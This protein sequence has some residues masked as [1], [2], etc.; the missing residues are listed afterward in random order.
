M[1]VFIW[2]GT[3]ASG[4]RIRGEL[5]AKNAKVVFNA[6]KSQ[7]INPIASKIKEKGKGL[8]MEI[9]LPW[10]M[11]RV[12]PKDIV[13]FT[14]QFTTMLDAGLPLVQALGILIKQADNATMKRVLNSI[15]DTIESGG[16]LAEGLSLHPKVFDE[17]YINMVAAG[18]SS[19]ALDQILE[20]LAIHM[21]KSIKLSREVKTAMIYPSV[22]VGT[23]A[24][25]T[26][27][28]LIF[29]IPTFAE[30]F[31]DFGQAL[32]LPTQ[33]VINLSNFMVNNLAI[34]IGI[35]GTLTTLFIKFA[36]STRGKEILHPVY[37]K[38]PII[39]RLIKKVSIARFS[40]TLATML[41]SGVALLE[42]MSICSRTA[43]NKVV[44]K[45]ILRARIGISEG[46]SI[47]EPLADSAVFPGMATQMI[48]V[49]E[50][51]GQLDKMLSKVADFYEE[52]VDT[53]VASLKQLIEP[54]IIL[55]LGIVVGSIIVAMYLPIFKLGSVI[56]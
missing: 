28:L 17:L 31:A 2:E 24:I 21:E 3:N 51:S 23:A 37:L 9:P 12:K 46:K 49:G 25:V 15:K 33:I 41:A 27:V 18:E 44:E 39:G 47:M 1:P 52:E 56:G 20:R 35:L 6:L 14:R 29:V 32:P 50:Q 5:E 42:A 7:K 38:I 11:T 40:R 53:E 45:E 34:I 55:V 19:G 48:S 13:I 8:D 30:M 43:G 54:I 26:S 4:K 22:V 16:T 36:A 10:T